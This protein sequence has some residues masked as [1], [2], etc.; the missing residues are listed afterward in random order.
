MTYKF[1]E[2]AHEKLGGNNINNRVQ[3]GSKR[4]QNWREKNE[5]EEQ[6]HEKLAR[7]RMK[8]GEQVYCKMGEKVHRKSRSKRMQYSGSA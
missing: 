6:M 3:L 5:I 1:G 8:I 2:Q 7:K 4:M